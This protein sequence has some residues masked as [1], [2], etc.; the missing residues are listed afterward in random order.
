MEPDIDYLRGPSQLQLTS[1]EVRDQ[2]LADMRAVIA[3][4]REAYRNHAE[5]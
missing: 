5:A 3:A 1:A 4:A 2:A